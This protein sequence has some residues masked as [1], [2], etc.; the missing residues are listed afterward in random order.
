MV[1]SEISLVDAAAAKELLGLDVGAGEAPLQQQRL[2]APV[3]GALLDR[4][5]KLGA[6]VVG[7]QPA[8]GHHQRLEHVR[9][10]EEIGSDDKVD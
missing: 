2:E 3:G 7:Q 9:V 10:E 1:A 4:A 8:H 5:D 6:R